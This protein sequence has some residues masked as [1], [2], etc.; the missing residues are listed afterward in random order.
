M[1]QA[2]QRPPVER[3]IRSSGGLYFKDGE[4]TVQAHE[5]T[6]YATLTEALRVR[7]AFGLEDI[8]LVTLTAP[9]DNFASWN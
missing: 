1:S 3:L 9:F 4:W 6:V 8:E 2:W 5:A 7:E